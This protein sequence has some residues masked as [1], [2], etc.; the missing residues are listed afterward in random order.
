MQTADSADAPAPSEEAEAGAPFLIG[1]IWAKAGIG[2]SQGI[3]AMSGIVS[4]TLVV[5]SLGM[6]LDGLRG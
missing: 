4:R 5:A 2:L 1:H 6:G 3:L